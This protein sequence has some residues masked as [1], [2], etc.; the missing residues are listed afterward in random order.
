[1]RKR[2]LAC[3]CLLALVAA[4]LSGC[5]KA[6]GSPKATPT[7]IPALPS[8]SPEPTP[9][10]EPTDEPSG[11]PDGPNGEGGDE[12]ALDDPSPSGE[13]DL[14]EADGEEGVTDMSAMANNA[15]LTPNPEETPIAIDPI[16]K[17]TREPLDLPF[18]AYESQSMK[19]S[20]ERPANWAS[21]APGETNVLFYEPKASAKYGY[22]AM[23]TV[24]V[25]HKGSAQNKDDAKVQLTELLDELGANTAWTNFDPGVIA[26]SSMAGAN[27]HYAYFNVTYDNKPL[28]GRMMVV[29]KGSALYMVRLTCASEAYPQYEDVYRKVRASW[30]FL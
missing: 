4:L 24:K 29:A 20:F 23:L 18:V 25:Y 1:M 22:Q 21:E 6:G 10:P 15:F 16:D 5:D 28:R 30:K 27:G 17:P 11:E 12:T 8:S 2:T 9:A 19:V 13:G 3:I 7:T 14:P 26:S